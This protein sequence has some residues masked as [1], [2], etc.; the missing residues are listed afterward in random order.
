M[1]GNIMSRGKYSILAYKHWPDGYKYK[2]NCYG[3][4]P[5]TWNQEVYD[6]GIPYDEK[7]MFDGYDEEGYDRYGYSAFDADGNYVGIGDG[8]DRA[9][10]T[11]SDYLTLQDI[12]EQHR[13][14]Y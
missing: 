11:E 12:P 4:E 9:G 6:S 5:A 8:V 10:Y 7:T 14:S 3:Q 13:D 1:K 2:Y